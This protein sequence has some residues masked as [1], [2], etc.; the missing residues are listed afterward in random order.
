[1]PLQNRVTPQ[2][3]I[4]AVPARGTFLG[5]R[6][7][8]FHDDRQQ[9]RTTHWKSRAWITCLLRFKNRRRALM[10]PGLYTELFF[11]DEVTALAAGHRPCFECRRADAKDFFSAWERSGRAPDIPRAPDMDLVLHGE[12][13]DDLKRKRTHTAPLDALPCG[14]MVLLDGT[15]YALA[16][17]RLLAWSHEGYTGVAPHVGNAELTVLTP[18]TTVEILKAGYQPHIHGSAEGLAPDHGLRTAPGE[19]NL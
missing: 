11:L 10:Q 16:D 15:A 18:P 13:V 1:M 7:G 12:R 9:L 6:G 3:E 4:V 14:T 19:E 8:C 2:G 5:N 17:G